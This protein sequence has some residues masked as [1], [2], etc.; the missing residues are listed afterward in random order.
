MSKR[1]ASRIEVLLIFASLL[2][3]LGMLLTSSAYGQGSSFLR[4][5]YINVGQ[6]DSIWL[7]ASDQ[8]DILIDGGPP[9]AGP[10]VVAYLQGKGVDDIDVMVLSHGDADHVGGLID[11][12]SSTIP[13]GSVIYNGEPS[14]STTYQNFVSAMQARGITPTPVVAG[15]VYTWGLMTGTVLNPQPAPVGEQ[16]EDSV[17]VMVVYSSTRF[18]FTGDIGTS[19]EQVILN[20]GELTKT[21]VLKVGHH[22]SRYSSGASFLNAITP[23]FAI[24]S[25]GDNNYGHPSAETL[26]R[27]AAAGATIYRTDQCGTVTATSDGQTVTVGCYRLLLPLVMSQAAPAPASDLRITTLSGT[28]TPEYVVIQ[29]FGAGAQ[30]MTGWR[31]LS[32]VGSQTFNFPSGYTLAAG[33]TVRLESYTGAVNNPPAVLL[34]STGAIWSNAG[35]KAILYD[36]SNAAVSS[37]CFGN[38]CP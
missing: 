3:V 18:L 5:S 7:H 2:I 25:V 28:T 21:D 31:V 8:T 35:D 11:V 30:D 1:R 20:S 32:V 29:N 22:G 10:T 38:A 12:L 14:S 36:S 24:I 23:T 19:T 16:N 13:V 33:A 9:A 37:M 27:L 4:V 34:W 17:V 15:Q 6:G 26:D